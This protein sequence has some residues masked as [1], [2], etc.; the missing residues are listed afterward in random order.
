VK[1]DTIERGSRWGAEGEGFEPPSPCGRRFSSSQPAVASGSALSQVIA[2]QWPCSDRTCKSLRD[3][4][5][6]C[7]ETFPEAFPCRR[8]VPVCVRLSDTSPDFSTGG[9][10]GARALAAALCESQQP[11]W[12][13]AW[14]RLATN[15]AKGRG[16][17][18]AAVGVIG[19]GLVGFDFTRGRSCRGKTASRTIPKSSVICGDDSRSA[20]RYPRIAPSRAFVSSD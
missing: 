11:A 6:V 1:T 12:G 14:P 2:K 10:V 8:S 15:G 16:E 4:A 20:C 18:F 5:P 13:A 7:G 3:F 9:G 17:I 19:Y